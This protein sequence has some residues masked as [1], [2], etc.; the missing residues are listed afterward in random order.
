MPLTP[1]TR[2]H[3]YEITAPIGAGGMGEVYRAHDARLG[4]DVAIKVLPAS[5]SADPQSL[6]RF[7]REARAIGALNHP[8]IVN[9]FDTGSDHGVSYVV[10]ELLEGET[11]RA[12]LEGPGAPTTGGSG[13]MPALRS[14]SGVRTGGLPKKKA[15]EIAQQLAQ[16][17]AA[18]HARG[19]VHRDL[20]PENIFL[21][22]DGRVK[23][24][25]FGL[26]RSTPEAAEQLAN[27]QTQV[28]PN[29]AADSL[30]G[31]V[32][33]TVGYMAPEQVR[34]QA[35]DHRADI[36]AFGVVLYEMLTG[37]RA[38]DGESHIETMSAIL[39]AD[40]L[41]QPAAAVAISGPL[42]PLLRHCLEKQPDERSEERR[43]GKE[44]R[45]GASSA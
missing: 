4:R 7:E 26:A 10:M 40:P 19:I 21:T 1:G 45:S 34:G 15:L 42:E 31:L 22:N 41:E 5:V 14:S 39:K 3:A 17:L 9:V 27:A 18:A 29:I 38:F 13:R 28:S 37:E 12:R 24:L 23:I 43:V 30:P 36:F 11:L 33:G 2:L 8:N 32:L 35:V 44:C 25:D 6:A 16:G 20:K